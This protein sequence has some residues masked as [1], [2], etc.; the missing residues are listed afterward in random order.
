M[1]LLYILS[2]LFV[3]SNIKAQEC[4]FT[5]CDMPISTCY[6]TDDY[7]F[8]WSSGL[9]SSNQIGGEQVITKISLSINSSGGGSSSIDGQKIWM[10]MTT[11]SS[12]SSCSFPG[13]SGFILVYSGTITYPSNGFLNIN[14]TTSS[15]NY[16]DDTKYLEVLWENTNPN[17]DYVQD[18]TFDRLDAN[19]SYVGKWGEN[20]Y[21]YNNATNNCSRLYYTAAIGFNETSNVNCGILPIKLKTF[22]AKKENNNVNINWITATE[23]NN[24]YFT[25]EHSLD[26]VNFRK[27]E[28]IKGGGN[29]NK[30]QKYSI[31]DN[32][33]DEGIN[34]YRLKQTDFDG[35]YTY[36]KIQAVNFTQSENSYVNIYPNPVIG[37]VLNIE[38]NSENSSINLY[39]CIG[40]KMK[41]TITNSSN[42]HIINVSELPKGIYFIETIVNGSSKYN[43]V[44]I[45]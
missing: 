25:I 8:A 32:N 17:Y 10:R 26:G 13:T 29:S 41:I 12:Y 28:T 35:T 43:K 33:P 7:N 37:Q 21:N 22:T 2:L 30:Q 38:T 9:Y 45:K 40:E 14:L 4:G 11:L 23:I 42:K 31:I 19:S 27:I 3:F 1:R 24:D 6:T 15:F 36:S 39:N 5:T 44:L 34:Y 16:N 20:N 18:W